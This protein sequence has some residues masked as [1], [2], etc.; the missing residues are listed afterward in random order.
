MHRVRML[1]HFGITPYIVFDGDYLPSKAVTEAG[2]A[3][4]R[5][6]SRTAGLELH[7]LG[8]VSQA[9]LELQKAVDV[10]P[11]MARQLIDELK[12]LDVQ[13]VV[14]PYEADV[15]LA[16]LEREGHISA[17][18][19]EDSDMLV[20]GA[21]CLLTKLD[22]YGDCVE[23]NRRDFTACREISLVGWSEAD[24]R[25]MAI[26][27]GCDYLA[28][29]TKMGL[30][31][32]YRLTRKHKTI[33]RIIRSL[34]FDGQFRVP[35]GY[36][37]A[38]RQAE[39]TFLHQWVFCPRRQMLVM[40]TELGDEA[41]EADLS[42]LGE[43]VPQEVAIGVAAGRL[44]PIT[45][46]ALEPRNQPLPITP[47]NNKLKNGRALSTGD[48]Q[49][50]DNMKGSK[51][52]DSFFK[53]KRTPLSELD[54][55][56]FTPSPHQQRTLEQNAGAIWSS[57][58]LVEQS[59]IRRST[60]NTTVQQSSTGGSGPREIWRRSIG[61]N[62]AVGSSARPKKR[63]RLCSD[64]SE[65][66]TEKS[67]AYEEIAKSK[68]FVSSAPEPS[69]TTR[70][71]P[72]RRKSRKTDIYIFSDDSIED[73]LALLPDVP[74]A[75]EESRGDPKSNNPE[76]KAE[77]DQVDRTSLFTEIEPRVAKNDLD[78]LEIIAANDGLPDNAQP[79][80]AF[81][82]RAVAEL[83]SLD[84]KFSYNPDQ[85]PKH[86]TATPLVTKSGTYKA[87]ESARST[88]VPRPDG[89]NSQGLQPTKPRNSTLQRLQIGAMHRVR[90][91][92]L[93]PE[94]AVIDI[95]SRGSILQLDFGDSESSDEDGNLP[96]HT[97]SG[98]CG[99]EDHIIPDSDQEDE[100]L[101]PVT[102]PLPN[103]SFDLS[104]FTFTRQ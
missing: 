43:P 96:E 17:I 24:F 62:V 47:W 8:R 38:F 32:A 6:E 29:I 1:Q 10:S 5:E 12:R 51:S 80:K 91:Q 90:P 26:L 49:T 36:L 94:K 4:R 61:S 3:K 44:N 52:I 28:S 30:K 9:H 92:N 73:D 48:I 54:P 20:F 66:G 88:D 95:L 104:K 56:S 63:V 40:N 89:I 33:D 100:S 23:I 64:Q 46:K 72:S 16:F 37:E 19:S 27:S 79:T 2:R 53:S 21:H 74:D 14:A 86:G 31:T 59:T 75:P 65:K 60:V 42:F 97:R 102:T 45:K 57:S 103:P 77:N 93:L 55:N 85:P 69:P 101:S 25:T 58:P 41:E 39:L 81:G 84:A 76:E 18:I 15:Q 34:Q 11:E 13:F 78:K 68:F 67:S 87:E 99:S 83:Q 35:N 98:P 70:K 71:S 7:R 82:N 22:Q 50:I